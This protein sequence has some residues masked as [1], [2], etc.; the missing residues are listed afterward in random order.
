MENWNIW[1]LTGGHWASAISFASRTEAEAW[2]EDECTQEHGAHAD[3]YEVRPIK[4]A[5]LAKYPVP[6]ITKEPAK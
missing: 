3:N 5:D 1:N 6:S 2:K 4:G